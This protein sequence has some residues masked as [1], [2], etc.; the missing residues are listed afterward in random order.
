MFSALFEVIDIDGTLFTGV[1]GEM[2]QGPLAAGEDHGVRDIR[3]TLRRWS[4]FYS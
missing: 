4:F 1:Y 3:E 2:K